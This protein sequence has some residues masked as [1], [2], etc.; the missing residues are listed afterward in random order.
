MFILADVYYSLH[1]DNN[2][3]RDKAG[4]NIIFY[5]NYSADIDGQKL[6]LEY[7]YYFNKSTRNL[8]VET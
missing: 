2:R 7:Y 8:V 3:Y 6:L 5:R 1:T 4:G